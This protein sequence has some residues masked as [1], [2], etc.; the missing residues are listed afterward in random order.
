VTEQDI[1]EQ[2]T[3][4]ASM[5]RHATPN[6]TM[7]THPA[8]HA[9]VSADAPTH[10]RTAGSTHGRT[11]LLAAGSLLVVPSALALVAPHV[12][13][14]IVAVALHGSHPELAWGTL[15]MLAGL[16]LTLAGLP[17][18]GRAHTEIAATLAAIGQ[19]L[20]DLW[21]LQPASPA[22]R[23]AHAHGDTPPRAWG[24]EPSTRRQAA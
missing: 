2:D 23:P 14:A 7:H 19:A 5:P 16:P 17:W 10:A 15:T 3:K 9:A 4:E 11:V 20:D 8:S 22:A 1:H 6:H 24:D 21:V 12:L 13:E 18:T